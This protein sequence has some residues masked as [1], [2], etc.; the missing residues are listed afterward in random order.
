MKLLSQIRERIGTVDT[1]SINVYDADRGTVRELS[2]EECK[3][4][5]GGYF[6]LPGGAG[7]GGGGFRGY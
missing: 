2:N 3:S 6:L 5:S 7:G 4:V 1:S